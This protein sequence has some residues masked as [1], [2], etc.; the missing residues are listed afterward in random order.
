MA[1]HALK[2]PVIGLALDGI[3][4][5]TD[6]TAWGGELLWVDADGDWQ[7]LGGLWPLRLPGG[8]VGAREPWRVAAAALHELGRGDEIETR[9]AP[10]VGAARARGV[11]RMLAAQLNC[12][13]TSSAG[14]W[15][16]AA[17]AALDLSVRQE[18]EAQAAMALEALA[19]AGLPAAGKLALP[20]LVDPDA[21]QRLDIRPLLTRLLAGTD[22]PDQAAAWFHLALAQGLADWAHAATVESGVRTVAL[23]GG[24]FYNAILREQLTQ[25][26]QARGLRVLTPDSSG[27]GDAG[28]AFGQ[29]WVAARAARVHQLQESLAC[30]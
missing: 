22:A 25:R 21:L 3:G 11:Q 19:R 20:R 1:E 23:G 7:R 17:A 18:H 28:L 10:H 8:D 4:H 6:G 13:P 5:G 2:E 9:F 24:C 26:L 15:F 12:P 29:A 30:A 27:C 16:D 14:R